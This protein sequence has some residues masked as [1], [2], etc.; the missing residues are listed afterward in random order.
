MRVKPMNHIKILIIS[1]SLFSCALFI[2]GHSEY[3]KA[4]KYYNDRSYD[5]AVEYAYSSLLIKTDNEKAIKLFELSFTNAV[6]YHNS[7]IGS[8]FKIA[9]DSKWPG[10][11]KEYRSLMKLNDIIR[12]LKPLLEKE[13]SYQIDFEYK[14]YS[15]QLSEANSSAA[16]Y[17][18]LLGMDFQKN[19]DKAS[20]KK[21]AINFRVTQEY[22]PNYLNSEE[23]YEKARANAV[24]SLLFREFEGA[25]KYSAFIREKVIE[26]QSGESKEFLRI[27]TRDELNT[28]L[29]EQAL[30]QSGIAENNYNEM[31]KLSGADHILGATALTSYKPPEK[32]INKNIAQEKEV[33]I[34]T[35][36]YVDSL[37]NE[38]KNEIKGTVK[39]QVNHFKK[40]S[41]ASMNLTYQIVNVNDN[42]TL[43]TGSVAQNKSYQYEWAT[44]KGDKRALNSKYSRL[45][46]RKEQFAPSK[47][48]LF[49]TVVE[50]ISKKLEKKI[51]SHYAD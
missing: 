35:E 16:S 20:Q 21:A 37:G 5:L 33:V 23:L 44:F 13:L 48:E 51:S 4:K 25:E 15:S 22:V 41:Q 39:A 7:T 31:T 12:K 27:I 8:L 2:P 19:I 46:N 45:V 11:A 26:H 17:H 50:I 49:L 1:L 40:N 3:S 47:D 10:I 38:Q 43:Y 14:D 30:I 34:R 9:D 29:S 42:E 36:T 24:F 32:I 28:I 18:Y 6:D